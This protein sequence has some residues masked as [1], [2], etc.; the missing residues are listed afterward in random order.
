MTARQ[1]VMIA[2][3]LRKWTWTYLAV[4]RKYRKSNCGLWTR[5]EAVLPRG[6]EVDHQNNQLVAEAAN[7]RRATAGEEVP[8]SLVCCF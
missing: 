7:R 2:A 1:V 8:Q 5:R 3:R 6:L 4:I